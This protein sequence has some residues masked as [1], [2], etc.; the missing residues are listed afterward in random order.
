MLPV[1]WVVHF[2]KAAKRSGI[3]NLRQIAAADVTKAKNEKNFLEKI[4]SKR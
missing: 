4:G 2:F 1:G 3:K